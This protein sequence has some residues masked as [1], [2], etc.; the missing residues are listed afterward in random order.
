MNRFRLP[1]VECCCE[2]HLKTRHISTVNGLRGMQST[3]SFEF[4]GL[5]SDLFLPTKDVYEANFMTFL[6][7]LLY[8]SVF[9]CTA[10]CRHCYF[11]RRNVKLMRRVPMI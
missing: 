10:Q 3:L 6:V 5:P 1:R 2:T 7:Y 4:T 9:F 11:L 8:I